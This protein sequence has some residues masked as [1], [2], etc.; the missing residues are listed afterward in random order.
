[1]VRTLLDLIYINTFCVI[2]I[3]HLHIDRVLKKV[4][5]RWMAKGAPYRDFPLKPFDCSLCASWW[6]GLAYILFS[7]NITI[8]RIVLPLV[9]AFFNPI[10]NNILIVCKDIIAHIDYETI[11]KGRNGGPQAS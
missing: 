4:V 5:W 3:D 2:C 8:G 11:F 6:L 10:I 7:G 9:V 1:M